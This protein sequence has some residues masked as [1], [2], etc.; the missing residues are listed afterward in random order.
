VRITFDP[1]KDASNRAKHGLSLADAARLDWFA[2]RVDV[3]H[4]VAGETRWRMI[5]PLD[6]LLVSMVFTRRATGVRAISLRRASRKERRL[7]EQ[8]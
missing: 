7:Y 6:G 8:R 3:A 4:T 5:A 2:G 1:A